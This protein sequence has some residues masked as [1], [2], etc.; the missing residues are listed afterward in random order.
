MWKISCLTALPPNQLQELKTN[1]DK[2]RNFVLYHATQGRIDSDQISDNQVR[3]LSE[4]KNSE[5]LSTAFWSSFINR[6]LACND[7]SSRTLVHGTEEKTFAFRP[8]R[9]LCLAELS[10][11]HSAIFIITKKI[12]TTARC[13]S[14]QGLMKTTCIFGHRVWSFTCSLLSWRKNVAFCGTLDWESGRI[15]GNCLVWSG[16]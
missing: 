8:L 12:Y 10:G 9:N 7:V 2:A 11:S 6:S 1:K 14:L 16:R 15:L 13:L 3:T 5:K 4:T